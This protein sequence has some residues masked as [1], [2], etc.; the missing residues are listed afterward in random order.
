[1]LLLPLQGFPDYSRLPEVL[2]DLQ[3]IN[4]NTLIGSRTAIALGLWY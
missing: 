4:E 3:D 1:M 2:P